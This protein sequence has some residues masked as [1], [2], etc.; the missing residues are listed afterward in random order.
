[1]LPPG[2]KMNCKTGNHSSARP[3]ALREPAH[4]RAH[5]GR[6][7]F[8]LIELLIVVAIVSVLIGILLPALSKA[9]R[10]ALVATEL[11]A[12]RQF[13]TAHQMY[14]G[15]HK[16]HLMPG[17]ATAAMVSRGQVIARN[18]AG[19]RLYGL[20]AQ[21]YPWRLL[22]YL[23]YELGVLYRDR[24]AIEDR[25][26]ES[27][28]DYAVSSGPRFGLN[29][30][31]I[32]GSGEAS[33]PGRGYAFTASPVIRRRVAAAWGTRWFVSR[34]SQVSRPAML[35][36]FASAWGSNPIDGVAIDGSYRITPPFMTARLWPSTQPNES[37]PPAHT[38][39]VSFRHDGRTAAVMLDGHAEM[40]D[41]RQIQ[42]MRRW[43][44]EATREDWTLPP[45]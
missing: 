25:F 27:L 33:D 6:A 3:P 12:G 22:G 1:M 32:G 31:F 11:S 23:E 17:F 36:A 29:Q 18:R 26:S 7:A 39:S 41:W 40:L 37:T 14:T 45:I 10:C 16:D 30:V 8:T 35:M 19:T 34:G 44:N 43:S 5:P 15:A 13:I 28:F 21:R 20:E 4:P 24:R 42:D 9:R 2:K 38:G